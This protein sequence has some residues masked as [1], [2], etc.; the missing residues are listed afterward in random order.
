MSGLLYGV[1]AGG[2]PFPGLRSFEAEESLLFFGRE[3]HTDELLERL[4]DN[5]F[6]AVTGTSGSGKSSLV[7]AGLRP[8][9]IAATWS[10][11]RRG[12]VSRRSGPARRQST[13]SRRR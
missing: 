10:M 1:S 13:R 5:R 4:G 8:A 11:P 3:A 9:T 6:V 2:A 7:R 12:G